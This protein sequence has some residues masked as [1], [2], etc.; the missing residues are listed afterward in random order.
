MQTT[1]DEST[2]NRV[3]SIVEEV[4]ESIGENT[5]QDNL[6]ILTCLQLAYS[7]EKIS[8]ILGPLEKELETLSPWEPPGE[9]KG[10][11]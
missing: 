1:L 2:F 6:L 11:G 3:L 9:S 5:D 8:K 10:D 4:G 7:L